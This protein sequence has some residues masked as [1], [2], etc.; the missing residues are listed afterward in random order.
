M[1]K[2]KLEKEISSYIGRL[3][4]EHFGRGPGS[5]FVSLSE[6]F[7]SVYITQFLSPTER[8]LLNTEQSTFVQKIRDM[9]ME[10]LTN[11]IRDYIKLQLGKDVQ[12]FYYDWN[13]DKQ[14]GMFVAVTGDRNVSVLPVYKNQEKVHYEMAEVSKEAEKYPDEIDSYLLNSRTL[15]IIRRKILVSIEQELIDL[16]FHEALRIAKRGLEKRLFEKHKP[17]FEAHLH[18]KIS[19]YFIDW[20]F[21]LDRSSTVLILDPTL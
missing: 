15:I 11:E 18:S 12:D 6:P 1:D 4:R 9:L 16:G 19:D 3:L 5:V 10:P 21:D 8:T 17:Q 14:T 7:I 2:T 20:N 13:L